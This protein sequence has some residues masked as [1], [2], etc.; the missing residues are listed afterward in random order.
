MRVEP[1]ENLDILQIA[2]TLLQTL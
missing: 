1:Y 2:E